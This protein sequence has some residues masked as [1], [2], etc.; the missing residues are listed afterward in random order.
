MTLEQPQNKQCNRCG[1]IR[2]YADY[3]IIRGSL[4]SY[5][6]DCRR[7]INLESKSRANIFQQINRREKN[8]LAQRRH[9]VRAANANAA[10]QQ[11]LPEMPG[12]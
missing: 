3:Y 7:A 12:N 10:R 4:D 8:K 9:K 6:K 11:T 2:D 1:L 5:C